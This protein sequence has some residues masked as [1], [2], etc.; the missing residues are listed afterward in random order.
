MDFFMYPVYTKC[1]MCVYTN[2]I[3]HFAFLFIHPL[4]TE[5]VCSF[6]EKNP[7][8]FWL[9]AVKVLFLSF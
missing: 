3:T 7:A 4:Y 2:T 1:I 9:T 8:Q 5:L 6:G